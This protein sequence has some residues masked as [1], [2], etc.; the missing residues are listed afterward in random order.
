MMMWGYNFMGGW[1]GMMFILILLLGIALYAFLKLL[2]NNHLGVKNQSALEI[3]DR[4]FANG[5]ISEEEYQ[6]KKFMLLK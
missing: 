2:G 3:L 5:E 6:K 1:F 4:K